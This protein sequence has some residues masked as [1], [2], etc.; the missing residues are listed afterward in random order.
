MRI[1]R[2]TSLLLASSLA[3]AALAAPPSATELMT[4]AK[5]KAKRE[6]KNVLVVYH[7]SWC[8]WCH[9][10]D[11]MLKSKEVGSTMSKAYVIVHL[12][13]DENKEHKQDE[14]PGA[15]D[16]RKEQ[17]GAEAGLPF[18]AVVSPEGKTVATSI[19]PKAGNTGYP[20][21]PNEISYFMTVLRSTTPK[22]NDADRAKIETYLKETASKLK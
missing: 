16:L 6:G 18:M 9:K 13:V 14:N 5:V 8:G 15:A 7:A 11:D 4:K 12:V 2:L 3:A 22:L 17:G 10:L 20:A 1:V 19:D 21:Q